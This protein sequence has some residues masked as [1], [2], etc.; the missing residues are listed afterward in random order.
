[1]DGGS[2]D[3]GYDGGIV[4][5][6]QVKH[7]AALCVIPLHDFAFSAF[8]VVPLC[9]AIGEIKSESAALVR[10]ERHIQWRVE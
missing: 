1:M 6:V 7:R 9:N 5:H 2:A 4:A 10:G 3:G 8:I